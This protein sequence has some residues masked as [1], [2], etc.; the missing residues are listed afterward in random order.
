LPA[1]RAQPQ[2]QRDRTAVFG[3]WQSW[4]EIWVRVRTLTV[5]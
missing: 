2:A 5:S 1:Y 4:D 3:E